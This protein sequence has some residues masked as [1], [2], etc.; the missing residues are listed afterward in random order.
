MPVN[1]T[2]EKL[3]RGEAVFGCIMP[4]PDPELVEIMGVV[5]IDFVRF[6]G[7]HG[8]LTFEQLEHCVRAAELFDIT[9]TARVPFNLPHEIL[10]F[11]DRGVVG[12]TVP[13]IQTRADAEA[14]VRAAKH[15]PLGERGH[16]A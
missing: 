7:E 2:K 12:V 1:R 5:G 13:N 16:N 8:P 6:E 14:A 10:R 9:P 11:L 4:Y 3:R 15:Y